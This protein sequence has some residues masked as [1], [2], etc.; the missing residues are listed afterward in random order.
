MYA[1]T[2]RYLLSSVAAIG[3]LLT[4]CNAP[5]QPTTVPNHILGPQSTS[6]P[7]VD[8]GDSSED[9]SDEVDGSSVVVQAAQSCRPKFSKSRTH[10]YFFILTIKV[11]NGCRWFA[12]DREEDGNY[13]DLT[14][15]NYED[16]NRLKYP[17]GVEGTGT[18]K[19][20]VHFIRKVGWEEHRTLILDVCPGSTCSPGG[21]HWR[22]RYTM[23]RGGEGR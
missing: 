23:P 13:W 18:Q 16:R 10:D 1:L 5:T 6:A 17:N 14:V 15:P 7:E 8:E 22:Y 3:M 2:N 9:A 20:G 11:G 12:I 19:I 21:P 4:A